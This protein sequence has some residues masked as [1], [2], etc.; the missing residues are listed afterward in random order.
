MTTLASILYAPKV[1][2]PKYTY[3]LPLRD[4]SKHF[5]PFHSS[6]H[7]T[8]KENELHL[9]NVDGDGGAVVRDMPRHD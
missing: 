2:N 3:K 8:T 5:L 7:M 1:S 9:Q 6:Q 4:T